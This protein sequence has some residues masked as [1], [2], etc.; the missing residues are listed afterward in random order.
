[1]GTNLNQTELQHCLTKLIKYE[2]RFLLFFLVG[3]LNFFNPSLINQ[4]GL[5]F[6]AYSMGLLLL[7]FLFQVYKLRK[8]R[9]ID[10]KHD[11]FNKAEGQIFFYK[12]ITYSVVQV[13]TYVTLPL[14]IVM[15]VYT[16]VHNGVPYEYLILGAAAV[17][18]GYCAGR[19]F[20]AKHME[21]IDEMIVLLERN[22]KTV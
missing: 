14:F 2:R 17:V 7:N 5:P 22:V 6:C 19:K 20:R 18:A 3:A 15:L 16:V 12:N 4:F 21:V 8:L 11:N 1:M 13:N 9:S 10:C